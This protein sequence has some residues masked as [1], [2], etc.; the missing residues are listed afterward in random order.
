MSTAMRLRGALVDAPRPVPDYG[1]NTASS[2][3]YCLYCKHAQPTEYQIVSHVRYAHFAGEDAA[4]AAG[5]DYTNGTHL[6][7]M[8][9]RW[10][11]WGL[12]VV[13]KFH[14]QVESLRGGDDFTQEV[15]DGVSE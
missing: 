8:R 2:W 12:G 3:W 10:D 13:D 9:R 14:L 4:L 11:E 7:V 5:E 6:R 1:P 15:G